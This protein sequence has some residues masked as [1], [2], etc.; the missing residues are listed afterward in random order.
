MGPSTLAGATVSIVDWSHESHRPSRGTSCHRRPGAAAPALGQGGAVAGPRPGER[1]RS[2]DAGNGHRS[3]TA[4]VRRDPP[5]RRRCVG[6]PGERRAADG[7]AGRHG[8]P[9]AP[10]A[11]SGTAG[12][13]PSGLGRRPRVRHPPARAAGA[14][15]VPGRRAGVARHRGRPDH[16]TAAAVPAALVGG[17]GH[18]AGR[19]RSGSRDRRPPR[20]G[21]RHRRSWPASPTTRPAGPARSSRAA[22][23]PPP[24]SPS[25]PWPGGCAR[26]PARPPRGGPCGRP[27]RPAAGWHRP[28]R[29]RAH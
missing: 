14:L 19:R 18:R 24:G 1:H 26:C 25:T 12:L 6:G 17:V 27:Y 8:A 15:P 29:P 4:A 28:A 23:R 13:R 2:G 10:A 5:A 9:A 20:A 3:G 21:R 22:H 11:A 16:R 7:R